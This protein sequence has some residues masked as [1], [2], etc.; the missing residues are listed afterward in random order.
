MKSVTD[1]CTPMFVA[2]LFTI[3]KMCKQRVSL[4]MN[5]GDILYTQWNII[6]P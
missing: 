3:T 4:Q 1:L 5:K 6:Q 2:E